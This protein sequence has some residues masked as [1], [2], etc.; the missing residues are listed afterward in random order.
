MIKPNIEDEESHHA[1]S[2][3]NREK[4]KKIVVN[5][6]AWLGSKELNS[7]SQKL[8]KIRKTS[9]YFILNFSITR[10]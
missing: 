1:S 5:L 3:T 8:T 6:K 9:N 7:N 2:S 10:P 4:A